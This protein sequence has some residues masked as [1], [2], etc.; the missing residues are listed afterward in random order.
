MLFTCQII[1]KDCI[2]FL[3][4]IYTSLYENKHWFKIYASFDIF[5]NV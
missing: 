3:I 1:A 5:F 4:N 2:K